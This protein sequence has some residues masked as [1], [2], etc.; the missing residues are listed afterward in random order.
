MT[1]VNR[2][3]QP[4]IYGIQ[5]AVNAVGEVDIDDDDI[6]NLNFNADDVA[7]TWG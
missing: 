4:G 2:S 6:H 1:T 3:T 5:G 7:E